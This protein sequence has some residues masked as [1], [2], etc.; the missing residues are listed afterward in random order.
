[1]KRSKIWKIPREVL[2][3]MFDEN[4]TVVDILSKLDLNPYSGNHR[5]LKLRIIEDNID[6]TLFN[7]NSKKYR[8]DFLSKNRKKISDDKIFCINSKYIFGNNLKKRLINAYNIPY[9][10]TICGNPGIHNGAKLNLQLDHI[11]GVHNDNRLEN[12]RFLCPN[13]H[14]QTCTFSG[15]K[16]KKPRKIKPSKIII[17]KTK[18]CWPDK[19]KLEQ[20]VWEKSMLAL[21]KELGVS[22]VTIAKKC[23]KLNISLPPIGYWARFNKTY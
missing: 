18:I 14:S 20:L 6:L 2:Q 22:D 12:L 13:C 5:T 17:H 1:M 9:K 16:A 15:K 23:K 10:C 8:E 7:I 3:K 11:N 4:S 19:E 21:S